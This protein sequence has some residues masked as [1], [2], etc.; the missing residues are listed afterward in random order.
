MTLASW[1]RALAEKHRPAVDRPQLFLQNWDVWDHQGWFEVCMKKFSMFIQYDEILYE[2]TDQSLLGMDSWLRRNG[3][4]SLS[5]ISRRANIKSR[6]LLSS[7]RSVGSVPFKPT[8]CQLVNVFELLFCSEHAQF[9]DQR[10]P[11]PYCRSSLSFTIPN[12]AWLT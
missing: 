6:L 2:E 3:K 11:T 4:A 12:Q 1:A 5:V 8:C 10:A 7:V 9:S